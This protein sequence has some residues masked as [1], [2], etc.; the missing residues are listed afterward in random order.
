MSVKTNNELKSE[1]K[2]TLEIIAGYVEDAFES[3]K[4]DDMESLEIE[5]YQLEHETKKAER[6]LD[7]I[8]DNEDES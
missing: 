1:I 4:Q 5:L 7:K 3:L 2:M 6:R 8:F